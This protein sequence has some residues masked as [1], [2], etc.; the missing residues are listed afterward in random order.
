MARRHCVRVSL[1]YTAYM[2]YSFRTIGKAAGI[3]LIDAVII[4][5]IMLPLVLGGVLPID[6]PFAVSFVKALFG[7]ATPLPVGIAFHLVYVTFWAT[8]FVLFWYQRP[9]VH[10][11]ILALVLWIGQAAIFYP[12]VGWGVFGSGVALSTMLIPLVPHAIFF[13]VL[14]TTGVILVRRKQERVAETTNDTSADESG[15]SARE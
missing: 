8:L 9:F 14:A 11:A 10:A 13:L 4:T 15:W 12:I 6:K 3:G 1:V 7:D 5:A 2:E